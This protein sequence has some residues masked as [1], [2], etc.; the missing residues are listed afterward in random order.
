MDFETL[1]GRLLDR[2]RRMVRNGD[3]TERGLARRVGLSQSHM[4]NVLCGRRILTTKAADTI[5]FSLGISVCDLATNA[6]RS[7]E[8]RG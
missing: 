3:M 7:A 1:L 8:P 5:L 6:E 4:H 2:L